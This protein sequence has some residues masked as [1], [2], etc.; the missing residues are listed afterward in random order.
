M[1][2]A[3]SGFLSK[4][5]VLKNAIKKAVNNFIKGN[6]SLLLVALGVAGFIF[7][8][9][10][11]FPLDNA[12]TS[13]KTSPFKEITFDRKNIAVSLLN[14]NLQAVR[15]SILYYKKNGNS[16]LDSAKLPAYQKE[17]TLIHKK[18]DSASF[19]NEEAFNSFFNQNFYIQNGITLDSVAS[20]LSTSIY[21]SLSTYD[22]LR[23]R[24]AIP[25]R[26]DKYLQSGDD[27]VLSNHIN[28]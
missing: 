1:K 25:T 8:D 21:D 16:W 26:K 2:P 10:I 19:L 28:F 20:L 22:P 13:K 12:F 27:T 24:R 7:T 9:I 6:F 11:L 17:A 23:K 18:K 5:K 15:D 4:T 3:E 14:A